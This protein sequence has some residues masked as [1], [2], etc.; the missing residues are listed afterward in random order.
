M[1]STRRRF[2]PSWQRQR[3]FTLLEMAVVVTVASILSWASFT[4]YETLRDDQDRNHAQTLT[5]E[6]QAHLRAFSMRHARLPC[7]DFSL[8]A[9]GLEDASTPCAGTDE[10]GW[11]PYISL[12]L[13][14]PEEA[15]RAR[16]GVFRAADSDVEKD[17][18]LAVA[19]ERTNDSVSDVHHLDVSDLIVALNNAAVM[20][21]SASHP[22][23]TGDG[24]AAGAVD[25]TTN[26]VLNVAY[27][28]VIPLKDRSGDGARLDPPQ[29]FN[30][31][32]VQSPA[33]PVT[34]ESDD[35]VLSESPVQLAGWLRQ[36]LP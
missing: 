18:D 31:P 3:A 1:A 2:S 15:W 13:V 9:I 11:F 32:C 12:G 35:V 23:L 25:C 34:A 8:S 16:Y 6:L 36:H 22:Y 21:V 19:K 26:S 7:P 29:T 20:P 28:L 5:R 27:W 24:G 4:A 14:M 33:A 30:G 10:I 17:A